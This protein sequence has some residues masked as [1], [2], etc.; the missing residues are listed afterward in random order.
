[1][2]LLKT[3]PDRL[4]MAVERR[5]LLVVAGLPGSGKS[6]MLRQVSGSEPVSVLDSDQ[7]RGWL[8]GLL[9][10][11]TPYPRYRPLVHALHRLRTAA[12]AA[13][14]PGPVVV[15]VPAT[16]AVTRLSMVLIGA[17]TGRP[18]HLLW[19]DA[20]PEQALA[21]Q[22]ERGRLIP[23]GSFGRHVARAA[24][25]RH[26]LSAPR[27][28]WGWRSATV[29]DRSGIAAGLHLHV[30]REGDRSSQMTA[31]GR[32]RAPARRREPSFVTNDRHWV[33][34]TGRTSGGRTS[35]ASPMRRLRL[36]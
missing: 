12:A 25:V 16:A 22:H 26:R 20:T 10:A 35:V 6:T 14:A 5:A 32:L 13:M 28:P 7:V 27:P 30:S 23:S 9:P 3:R 33:S 11:G 18:R 24:R 8:A 2:M 34:G 21:G 31:H 15:H 17:A 19:V 4:T 36:V 1:M 29:V